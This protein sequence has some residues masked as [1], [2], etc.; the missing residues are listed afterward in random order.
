[1]NRYI[2]HKLYTSS[3]FKWYKKISSRVLI[4]KK[5]GLSL[6]IAMRMIV[7]QLKSNL[8]VSHSKAVAYN[9]TL[10]IFPTIIFLFTLIPFLSESLHIQQ[11]TEKT[12]LKYLSE[13]IPLE[14]YQGVESTILDIISNKKGDLLS[15]GVI[16]ALV[17]ATNGMMALMHS[18][19][20]IYRTIEKR[21]QLKVRFIAV[22]LTIALSL[23]LTSS[24][25][26]L[27]FGESILTLISEHSG[28]ITQTVI[29]KILEYR[30]MEFLVF[31]MLFQVAISTIYVFAPAV[32][33]RW[34]FF[35][36]GSIFA[37]LGILLVS[38]V[39]GFYINNFGSYNKIYG[40][41]GTLIG[42]MIWVQAIAYVL[43]VGYIINAGIDEAKSKIF[44][45]N[46]T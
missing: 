26:V 18:F 13:S 14:M 35:S 12:I 21:G 4:D 39:F 33:K 10:A 11:F 37:T 17:M 43:I 25:L 34:K 8:L 36:A 19:N 5:S 23:V 7:S 44:S 31:G 22:L 3:L 2:V 24:F 15:F 28:R 41:I 1:M 30:G 27:I 42:F 16:F 32:Q 46:N 38:L 20:L 6:Y 45:K 29:S 40:S 9:F